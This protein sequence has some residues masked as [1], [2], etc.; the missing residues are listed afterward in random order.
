MN[1]D[2]SKYTIEEFELA[3]SQILQMAVSDISLKKERK[4][5]ILGGQP[6]AGKSTFFK[7]N[8]NL[9]DYFII[10]GD[11]YRQYHPLYE[12]IVRDKIHEMPQL[13]KSFS[14]QVVERLITDLGNEGYNVI[15]E[16]T[17]RNPNV[18]LQTCKELVSKGYIAH[19]VVVT[20]NAEVAWKSTL[21]RANEMLKAGEYPRLVPIDTYNSIVNNISANLEMI[22]KKNCFATISLIDRNG[23]ELYPNNEGLT[24]N[25][26]L[27]KELGLK[28]WNLKYDYFSKEFKNII[29]N[30]VIPQKSAKSLKDRIA[31]KQNI[32]KQKENCK[33]QTNYK[34][35][36]NEYEI[37]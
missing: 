1:K 37:D 24:P 26:V 18:P 6:G 3:Y 32:I 29:Q 27:E 2:F 15:I 5:Y 9:N 28:D 21:T 35:K 31:E 30:S 36:S 19:L 12:K 4:A 7:N 22:Y 17:L 8:Q 34:A 25:Q 14:G 11:D 20:C 16:G 13:T 10:N 33:E 23:K